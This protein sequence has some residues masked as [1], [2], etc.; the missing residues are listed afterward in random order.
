MASVDGSEVNRLRQWFPRYL[1][2]FDVD[3]GPSRY[4]RQPRTTGFQRPT[5]LTETH[6]LNRLHLYY[7]IAHWECPFF[8]RPEHTFS[9][10]CVPQLRSQYLELPTPFI[11]K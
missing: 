1:H 7:L 2:V 9:V 5:Y 3:S 10:K 8:F 6:F 4:P 11:R